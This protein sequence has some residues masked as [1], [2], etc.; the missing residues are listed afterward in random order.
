MT[1]DQKRGSDMEVTLQILSKSLRRDIGWDDKKYEEVFQFEGDTIA[2]LLKVVRDGEGRS[3]YDRF[4]DGEGLISRSYIHL[5]GISYLRP[6]DL[7]R[8]LKDG[9]KMSILGQ[10]ALCGGG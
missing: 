8:T 6:E 10:L 3:L 4:M 2:D 5:D 7:Q 9:G 1:D